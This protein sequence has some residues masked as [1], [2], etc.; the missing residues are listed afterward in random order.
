MSLSV[1][2][3]TCSTGL[4][5][6]PVDRPLLWLLPPRLMTQCWGGFGQ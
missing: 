4:T 3:V 2:S 5:F 6:P 1:I